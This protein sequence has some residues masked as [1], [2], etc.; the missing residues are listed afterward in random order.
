MYLCLIPRKSYLRIRYCA[1]L[2]TQSFGS[3]QIMERVGL[4]AYKFALPHTIKEHGVLHPF[5]NKK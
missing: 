4:V 1:K 3:F 2:A 5:L